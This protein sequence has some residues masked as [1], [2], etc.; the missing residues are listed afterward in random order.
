MARKANGCHQWVLLETARGDVIVTEKRGDEPLTWDVNPE[1]WETRFKRGKVV[2]SAECTERKLTLRHIWDHSAS[3]PNNDWDSYARS[4]Y[5]FTSGDDRPEPPDAVGE[6]P[7]PQQSHSGGLP[8]VFDLDLFRNFDVSLVVVEPLEPVDGQFRRHG[9]RC[10]LLRHVLTPE[11]CE[12]LIREMSGDMAPVKYRHDYRR[13]DRCIFESTELAELLWQ[14]VRPIAEGLAISVDIDASKQHLLTEEAGECPAELRVGYGY[15][16]VWRPTGLNECLRFCKYNPGGFFRQHCDATFRRSEDEMSLFTCMFYL[17]GDFGGGA[18]RFLDSNGA[19][20]QESSLKQ[21]EDARVLASVAPE[22]GLC[23]LFFQPGLLHEGEDLHDGVKYI[24]RSDM[25]FRR[26]PGT[27]PRKTP[28]QAEA[29]E[30][31]RQAQAAEE[32]AD[33][34]RAANLYRRAFKLDPRLERMV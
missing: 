8:I 22:P 17:N 7:P 20:S 27:K 5:R 23:I 33:C 19:I 6:P 29:M 3:A 13:N 31:L 11:E 2:R 28:Q 1:G 14:R 30:L 16:G 9:G 24:L 15:E 10:L 21:A 26:D 32:G 12:Y 34:D 18:T 25:M 4:M